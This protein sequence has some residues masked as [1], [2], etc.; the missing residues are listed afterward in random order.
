VAQA[1]SRRLM[2]VKRSNRITSASF[3]RNAPCRGGISDLVSRLRSTSIGR[4]SCISSFS[5][6]SREVEGSA[7]K[8]AHP[9]RADARRP[10][11]ANRSR[12]ALF[13]VL[14]TL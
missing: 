10:M 13:S 12:L 7:L 14:P 8:G 11:F 1:F 5:Q 6:S 2:K 9:A 4:S 3:F